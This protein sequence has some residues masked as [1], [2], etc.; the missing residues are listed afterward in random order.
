MSLRIT[1]TALS[2]AR[3]AIEKLSSAVV[4]SADQPTA[5]TPVAAQPADAFTDRDAGLFSRIQNLFKRQFESVAKDES[6]F[7]SVMKLV[8]GESHDQ[9]A[10]E[11]LRQK[12]LAGDYGWLPPIRFIDDEHMNGGYGAY[13]SK[14]QAI[15]LNASLRDNLKLAS[16]TFVEEVG[17]VIDVWINKTDTRGD[18]GELFRRVLAGENLTDEQLAA[19]RAEDDTGKITVDGKKVDVEFYG[20]RMVYRRVISYKLRGDWGARNIFKTVVRWVP[21]FHGKNRKPVRKLI[22]FTSLRIA[23]SVQRVVWRGGS[24]VVQSFRSVVS[25]AVAQIIT[26]RG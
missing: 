16:E 10:A 4:E 9:A 8:F 5:A 1:G 7:G 22:R 11:Q 12:S 19:I 2:A 15:Y 25:K 14:E 21:D 6:L 24:S 26:R 23:S 13:D 18:E 20:M 3:S 17:H